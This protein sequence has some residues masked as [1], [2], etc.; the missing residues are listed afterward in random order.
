M[1][2][3]NKDLNLLIV[4]SALYRYKNV[5]KAAHEL[6]LSQS[7]V[8]HALARLRVQFKDPMFVRTSRG[9]A[10]TE[11]ARS[12][13]E[14]LLRVV[15][16]TDLL[17]NKQKIFDPKS[18]EA[19]VTIATTDYFEAV[20][21]SRLYPVLAKEAPHLQLSVRPTSGELP[22]RELE[23]GKIDLAIAGFYLDMPE[24]FYQTKL[25][26]DPFACAVRRGNPDFKEDPI[27]L[28][29]YFGADHAL[30]TLQG[31]FRDQ[32]GHKIGRT[33]RERKIK[34][35]SYSFTGIAWVLSQSNLLLTAP[36]SLLREYKKH[37]DVKILINPVSILPI[38]IVLSALDR[39]SSDMKLR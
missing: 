24:G 33:K 27:S 3:Q 28:D 11:F 16:Q 12:I 38:N 15:D 20:V 34:Y 9:I 32:I 7:A 22:K 30:I 37:F 18:A 17:F 35:G 5:S 29:D 10:P 36:E 21:I 25:M 13:Q 6:G 1:H 4:A 39:H 23:E 14:E 31:D 2:I 26:T 19:R 8:S